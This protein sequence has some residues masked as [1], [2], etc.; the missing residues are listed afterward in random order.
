MNTHEDS[1]TLGMLYE[2]VI[3]NREDCVHSK[4][5]LTVSLNVLSATVA[6]LDSS[7]TKIEEHNLAIFNKLSENGVAHQRNS[8][9]IK[10]MMTICSGMFVA[11]V[12]AI[13]AFVLNH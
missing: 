7:M 6:R 13:L 3:R 4:S 12:S 8:D 10:W 2:M 1:L 11:F 9:L 5:N